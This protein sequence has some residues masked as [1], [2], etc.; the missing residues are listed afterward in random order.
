M[1]QVFVLPLL[2]I[3]QLGAA[4]PCKPVSS[5]FTTISVEIT[6]LPT[7]ASS[8]DVSSTSPPLTE[9]FSTSISESMSVSET[10]A[11][12]TGAS[13]T[14]TS[15][16]SMSEPTFVSETETALSETIPTFAPETEISTTLVKTS[17][18][19]PTTTTTSVIEPTNVLANPGFES[20]SVSP[21]HR[22]GQ[23]GEVTLT[24]EETHSGAYSGHYSADLNGPVVLGVDHPIDRDL[25]TVNQE[26]TYSIWIKTTV[27]N[28]CN[29]RH[30]TC[31]SG[32]GHFK[33][34]EWAG[35]YG[36]WTQFT[37]SCTWSQDFLDL[38]PSIQI[39]GECQSLEFDVDDAIVIEAN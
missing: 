26:Y 25:I 3:C 20:A 19:E 17:S 7:L 5:T 37:M 22:I 28:N 29:T 38:G 27:A 8:T 18:A 35:P 24:D 6:A 10:D 30:I 16:T 34:E 31:G 13:L 14:E 36:V 32:G 12:S 23:F 1:L 11:L 33:R 9:T 2:A 4:S 39:R 21:W 15:T